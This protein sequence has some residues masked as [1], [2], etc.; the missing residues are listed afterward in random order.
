MF[1]KKV[2]NLHSFLN[3]SIAVCTGVF[4]LFTLICYALMN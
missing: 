2:M 1:N 3:D 4:V